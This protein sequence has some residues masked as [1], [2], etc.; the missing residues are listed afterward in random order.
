MNRNRISLN[1]SAC[2][3]SSV[4]AGD[5]KGAL[6]QPRTPAIP[7]VA[8]KIVPMVFAFIPCITALGCTEQAITLTH[9]PGFQVKEFAALQ[10][11]Q[12]DGFNPLWIIFAAHLLRRES[13]GWAQPFSQL[14]AKH[15]SLRFFVEICLRLPLAAAGSATESGGVDSVVSYIKRLSA[16]LACFCNHVCII[17]HCMGS[18]TTGV[19]CVKTGRNFIGIELDPGYF[20]IAEKRI[21]EAQMQLPL[22]EVG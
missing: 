3:A 5:R 7:I 13:I 1:L 18:G 10:A 14:V 22:L 17:P 12:F 6:G 19:A 4:V 9:Y 20:A 16:H 21:A 11:S 15:V 8:T 2:L